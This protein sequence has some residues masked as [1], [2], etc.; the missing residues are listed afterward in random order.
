VKIPKIC[1]LQI[2]ISKLEGDKVI[3]ANSAEREFHSYNKAPTNYLLN[4]NCNVPLKKILATVIVRFS[5]TEYR[6]G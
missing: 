3:L 5:I 6:R 1:H 2:L 4:S